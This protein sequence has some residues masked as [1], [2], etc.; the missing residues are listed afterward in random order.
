MDRRK[1][2]RHE[3]GGTVWFHWKDMLQMREQTGSLRNVSAEGLYV[4][5]AEAPP[6]GTEI[7]L[8]FD[9]VSPGKVSSVLIAARGLVSRVEATGIE[10]AQPGFA[11]STGRMKVR[12]GVPT[13]LL[14]PVQ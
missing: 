11:V 3:V 9:F 2:E 7:A 10:G 13:S 14:G 6:V 4:E 12:K 8:Q 5:T 1:S